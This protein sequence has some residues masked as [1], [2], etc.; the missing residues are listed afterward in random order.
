MTIDYEIW[1]AM[2]V[3]EKKAYVES[4]PEEETLFSD[5]L[6]DSDSINQE[7]KQALYA[8]MPGALAVVTF[9]SVVFAISP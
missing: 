7:W 3:E 2:S 4:V 6:G 5:S 9:T 1:N 8:A